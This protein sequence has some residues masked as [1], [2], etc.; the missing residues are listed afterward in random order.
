MQG[1]IEASSWLVFRPDECFR[2]VKLQAD[3]HAGSS[4]AQPSTLCAAIVQNYE[5]VDVS[6]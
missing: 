1:D 5:F 4:S 3:A 2:E 6:W